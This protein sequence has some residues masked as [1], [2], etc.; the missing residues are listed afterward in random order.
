[1]KPIATL[2]YVQSST[3]GGPHWAHRKVYDVATTENPEIVRAL[4]KL[5]GSI[6]GGSEYL[7][8]IP[9]NKSDVL[10]PERN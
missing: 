9:A 4:I 5:P 7:A 6:D 10:Y 2:R 8:W 1:M 3:I